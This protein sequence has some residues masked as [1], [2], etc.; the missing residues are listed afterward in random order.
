MRLKGSSVDWLYNPEM[1]P[2]GS[3]S[4]PIRSPQYG[5]VGGAAQMTHGGGK[6]GVRQQFVEIPGQAA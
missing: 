5:V 6:A 3:F 1:L 2:S 4:T